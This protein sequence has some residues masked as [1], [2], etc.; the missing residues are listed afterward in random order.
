MPWPRARCAAKALLSA[1]SGV[2]VRQGV[3]VTRQDVDAE[4]DAMSRRFNVPR[5]K[6]IE[7]I[8]QE[9]GVTARQYA[10][11]IVWPMIAL[12]RLAHAS[13]EPT[14]TEVANAFDNQ[15]GPAVKAR[16]IVS[17]SRDEAERLRARAL[18]APDDFGALARQHSIDVG[19]ASA[20]G[21]V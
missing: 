21:W 19:S 16:I 18:S 4:I 1:V 8:Q 5:D 11:E 17:R 2:P 20:N 3:A 13:I 9:R 14:P 7:L 10:D 12:R 15:F 6:W